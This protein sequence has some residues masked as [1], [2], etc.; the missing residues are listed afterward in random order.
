MRRAPMTIGTISTHKPRDVHLLN[1][2]QDEPSKV[3]FQ[4]PLPQVRW[5]QQNLIP[6]TSYE[7]LGH[8]S[9]VL[10]RRTAPLYATVTVQSGSGEPGLPHARLAVLG[11]RLQLDQQRAC[12]HAKAVV[13]GRVRV[14]ATRPPC[15]CSGFRSCVVGRGGGVIVTGVAQ[16]LR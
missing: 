12:C 7:V 3:F 9:I 4:Q 1:G 14:V 6:V 15:H 10:T 2:S 16:D 5:Q 13:G 11:D 8:A